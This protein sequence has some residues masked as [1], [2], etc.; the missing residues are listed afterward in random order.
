MDTIRL[1]AAFKAGDLDTLR[2]LLGD[3]S[4]FP[5]CIVPGGHGHCLEYAIYHSPISL[6]RELLELGANPDYEDNAGFPSL[7]AALSS[8]RRD[9]LEI[10][11]VLL[12]AGAD[13]NQRGVNDYTPLHRA[14]SDND[15]KAIALL[16]THGA[17]LNA[18]TRIDDYATPREEAELLGRAD[19]VAALKAAAERA[20]EQSGD[21]KG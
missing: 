4:G 1:D 5:D 8:G 12:S 21:E 18:R 14:A 7:I 19:A 2:S 17:D 20:E 10:V 3:V 13:V 16:L 15:P 11:E 6:I 9:R